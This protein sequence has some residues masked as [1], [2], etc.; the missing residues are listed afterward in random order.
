MTWTSFSNF[1]QELK[2][3]QVWTIALELNCSVYWQVNYV[4]LGQ[5]R[6]SMFN[7]HTELCVRLTSRCSTPL[8]PPKSMWSMW[9]GCR[10]SSRPSENLIVKSEWHQKTGRRLQKTRDAGGTNSRLLFNFFGGR[11]LESNEMESIPVS[12]QK[13][14]IA[15][16]WRRKQFI[17]IPSKNKKRRSIVQYGLLG[18]DGR[19]EVGRC[20]SEIYTYSLISGLSVLNS[21]LAYSTL[22][23]TFIILFVNSS[24]FEVLQIDSSTCQPVTY[25]AESSIPDPE[26]SSSVSWDATCAFTF[27]NW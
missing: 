2:I 19:V 14:K 21:F 1:K 6:P 15:S 12:G 24:S 18:H 16:Q 11:K 17:L 25:S 7:L 26:P 13:K 4:K 22:P 20:L 5:Y 10:D 9:K 27:V 23:I 3:D 8:P